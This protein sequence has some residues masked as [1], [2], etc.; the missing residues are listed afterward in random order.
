MN[1]LLEIAK[2]FDFSGFSEKPISQELGRSEWEWSNSSPCPEF[3]KLLPRKLKDRAGNDVEISQS[4][5]KG[6]R[7]VIEKEV[8]PRRFYATSVSKT[9]KEVCS[10]AMYAGTRFEYL[11]TDQLGRDGD[12]D[13]P[14]LT[15]TGKIGADE[16]RVKANADIA[17][18]SLLDYGINLEKAKTGV[19]MKYKCL[20]GI[21]DVEIR[22]KLTADIKYSGL[23]GSAGKWSN[24]GWTTENVRNGFNAQC[25]AR[26]YTLLR[27]LKSGKRY[28]FEF[29]VFDNR[30]SNVGEVHVFRL[31]FS[32]IAINEHKWLILKIIEEF[33]RWIEGDMFQSIPSYSKCNSCPVIECSDRATKREKVLLEI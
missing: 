12:G 20:G 24:V 30:P 32:D 25:Q 14:I 17:K 27:E 19:K 6:F 15:K 18:K 4:F 28:P 1:K 11:L 22:G 31:T 33:L 2:N 7:K 9:H 13:E 5:I 8:C 10:D 16:S 23:V 21:S 3:K 29:Y 26:H